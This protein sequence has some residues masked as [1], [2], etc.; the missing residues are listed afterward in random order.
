MLLEKG[1]RWAGDPQFC[2]LPFALLSIA[3]PGHWQL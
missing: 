1:Q 3:L 2:E